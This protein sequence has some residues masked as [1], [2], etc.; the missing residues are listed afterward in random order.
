MTSTDYAA[1]NY[2]LA[3][4]S[5]SAYETQLAEKLAI[6]QRDF[7]EFQLPA[8]EVFRS[9]E[10][11]YRMRAEFR[12][13]HKGDKV[14]YV[15]FS[16]DEYKRP[17]DV[18]HFP[19]GSLLMNELM[20]KLLAVLNRTPILRDTLFQAD[21]L[22]TLS[23]DALITLIYNKPIK[24]EWLTAATAA[25]EELGAGLI[26]RSRGVKL[27]VGRDHVI[28]KLTVN[29][30]VFSYQQIESSFT[31][32]NATVCE[33]ML[34]WAVNKSK[35]FGGDLVELYCGNGNF[36]LPLSHNFKQVLATE[37][38]K[39]AVNSALFNIALN[40]IDNIKI[41]RMSSEEFSQAIDGVREFNRLKHVTLSDY[42]FSTIFVDPP[43]AGMDPHTT[44]VTQ[45]FDNIIYISC[46]PDTLRNNLRTLTETHEITAF[47]AFDQFPYTHHLE[48]GAMLKKKR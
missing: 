12:V 32:P 24:S 34:S 8:I 38:A 27:V 45:R 25:Q 37:L 33:Q 36:T 4:Y 42:K 10:K 18:E 22:T 20:Q 5:T 23:G 41:G 11:H 3:D 28:E 31:Q 48:C 19:V 17:Y 6:I 21:F 1:T 46:N 44:S 15:M 39:P 14:T 40:N 7:A 26:G 47:A 30:K 2:T 29:G 43:R 9:P 35:D 16:N 13:W